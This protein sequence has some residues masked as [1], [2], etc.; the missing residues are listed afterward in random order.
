MDCRPIRAKISDKYR[1][2]PS[3]L[4][5]SPHLFD[6][7]RINASIFTYPILLVLILRFRFFFGEY[8]F[9]FSSFV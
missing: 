3:A 7:H 1:E 9:A 6:S 5:G 4:D 8:S 2:N